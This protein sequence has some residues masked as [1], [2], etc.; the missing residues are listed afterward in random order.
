MDQHAPR[1]SH[2]ARG[3]L[4]AIVL[5]GSIAGQP[6]RSQPLNVEE[7][8]RC[9]EEPVIGAAGCTDRREA[10]IGNCTL[11]HTF[12]PIVLQQF[13]RPA[14]GSL[15]ERHVNSFATWLSEAQAAEIVDYLATNF[16]PGLDPPE[17]P[18]DL[19]NT[20]TAY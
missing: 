4:T 9:A 10:I 14:W 15:M 13:D 18:P 16:R 6:A 3:F 11:C 17:L 8:L 12:V 2:F 20:W 1:R 5:A 7:I 19:L